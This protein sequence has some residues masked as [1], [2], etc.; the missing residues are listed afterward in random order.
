MALSPVNNTV[1][2]AHLRLHGT[3]R[4]HTP[5]GHMDRSL[6]FSNNRVGH[7]I[8]QRRG[9]VVVDQRRAA[10][11][12]AQ[13]STYVHFFGSVQDEELHAKQKQQQQKHPQHN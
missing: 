13:Y 3:T 9:L 7:R 2:K 8:A 10:R 6:S 12:S 1:G 5:A 11:L 4:K